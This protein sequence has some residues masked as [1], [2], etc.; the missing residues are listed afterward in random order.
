MDEDA[1]E[2]LSQGEQKYHSLK[3]EWKTGS[4]GG[5]KGSD[6]CDLGQTDLHLGIHISHRD[7]GEN[8]HPSHLL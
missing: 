8:G 7:K 5:E 1:S 2:I 3:E 4:K 6:V